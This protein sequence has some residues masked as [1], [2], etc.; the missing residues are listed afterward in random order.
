MSVS[1]ALRDFCLELEKKFPLC[2][3]TK[4]VVDQ[5]L[6]SLLDMQAD[7]KGAEFLYFFRVR[8]SSRF[9]KEKLRLF[10]FD[11][12]VLMENKEAQAFVKQVVK[13]PQELSIALP[14][15]WK[16]ATR[17]SEGV[18]S[19]FCVDGQ[20]HAA[21]EKCGIPLSYILQGSNDG[22]RWSV[23]YHHP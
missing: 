11:F 20:T 5:H 7:P 14:R 17:L 10:R 15:G 13:Q 23:Q 4:D 21:I 9:S 22:S 1:H 2:F 16:L 3:E 18:V 12:D 8:Y 19:V 6:A